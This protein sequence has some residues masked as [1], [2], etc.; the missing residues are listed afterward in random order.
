MVDIHMSHRDISSLHELI[1]DGFSVV[2][3]VIGYMK[4]TL[5]LSA[6]RL[7]II[8]IEQLY[9]TLE[10]QGATRPSSRSCGWL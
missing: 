6:K 9:F 2:L 7:T 5:L 4:L 3:S 8:T 1:S 10:F